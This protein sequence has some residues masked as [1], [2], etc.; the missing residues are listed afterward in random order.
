MLSESP[1]NSRRP[2]GFF[3]SWAVLAAGT[4]DA[5]ESFALLRVLLGKGDSRGLARLVGWCVGIKFLLV[6]SSIGY[7]LLQGVGV[8]AGK[9]RAVS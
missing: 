8:V 6:F 5:V 4:L 3:I 7:L 9:V 1:Q 2:W